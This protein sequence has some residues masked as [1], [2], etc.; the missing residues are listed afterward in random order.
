MTDP[1]ADYLTRI[2]NGLQA[3]KISVDIP[4]TTLKRDISRILLREKFIPAIFVFGTASRGSSVSIS[5][6]LLKVEAL[7][8]T[9]RESPVRDGASTI[10]WI[11]YPAY[12]VA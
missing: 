7:L 3:K 10:R 6:T 11:A 4:E 12:S 5:S 1:I 9:C 2:R 8:M